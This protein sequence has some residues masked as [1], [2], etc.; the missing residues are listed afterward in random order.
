MTEGNELWRRW[1][2]E[3]K[4]EGWHV[5]VHRKCSI[6]YFY[7]LQR[8]SILFTSSVCPALYFAPC[9]L[10]GVFCLGQWVSR[11]GEVCCCVCVWGMGG[12][13]CGVRTRLYQNRA[14]GMYTS[15]KI[16]HIMTKVKIDKL[17][18]PDRN[19]YYTHYLPYI[20]ESQ[21]V[22]WQDPL[23]V[24]ITTKEKVMLYVYQKETRVKSR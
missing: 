3:D 17:F 1:S 13:G 16:I 10:C 15:G 8:N 2:Q 6:V 22:R 23:R 18:L 20:S 4:W 7:Y 21:M 12:K 24:F 19:Q 14:G 9:T 11:D 5:C